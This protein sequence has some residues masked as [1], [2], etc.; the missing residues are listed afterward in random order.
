MVPPKGEKSVS[1]EMTKWEYKTEHGDY[2]EATLNEWGLQGWELVAVIA[3]KENGQLVYT[4]FFKRPK[5][6]KRG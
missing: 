1:Q 5:Q 2:G 3:D 6:A 4:F